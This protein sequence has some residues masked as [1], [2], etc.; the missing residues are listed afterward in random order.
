LVQSQA[1][2]VLPFILVRD[3]R[4][5]EAWIEARQVSGAVLRAARDYWKAYAS[6]VFAQL[7]RAALSVQLNIAEGYAL[8]GHRRFANHLTIAYGSAIE[9][10]ELLELAR[11]EGILPAPLA[12]DIVNRSER[13]Q[14]L[15]LGLIKRYRTGE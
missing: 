2:K 4:S 8:K 5:L 6:A 15:L 10:Q 14:R 9:T 7:E 1:D 3:H 11:D 13:C 12:Q